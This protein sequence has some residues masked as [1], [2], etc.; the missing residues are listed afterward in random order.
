MPSCVAPY[1]QFPVRLPRNLGGRNSARHEVERPLLR[2]AD[3]EG[4]RSGACSRLGDSVR[5]APP[6]LL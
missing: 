3:A 2:R 4:R 6:G 1:R 5:G